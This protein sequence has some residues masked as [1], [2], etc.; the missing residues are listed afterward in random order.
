MGMA[1]TVEITSSA[2]RICRENHDQI[3]GLETLPVPPG[4]DP[5]ASL[6]TAQISGALGKVTVVM[7]HQDMLLRT[8]LQPPCP[9][10][11]L[12]RIVRFELQGISREEAEPTETAWHVVQG[13]G[14]DDMRI[15]AMITKRSLITALS[16]ALAAHG[17]KLAGLVH[18]AVG[19]YHA[20]KRQDPSYR[21]DA[22]IADIGGKN[23]HLALVRDGELLFLRSQTPGMDDLT[24]A[25]AELRSIAKP[26]AERL[27]AKLGKG[28][29]DDLHE[30]IRRQV[31]ALSGVIGNNVRFAKAQLHLDA[32]EPKAIYLAG[33]GAQV[34]GFTEALAERMHA[35]VRILNPFAGV[36]MR[37]DNEHLDRVAALPSPWVA[38]FGAALADKRELD[39]LSEAR[40]RRL[41]FWRSDGAVR[42]ACALALSL[43]L[44]AGV[45][46]TLAGMSYGSVVE[47]LRG[48]EES[49]GLVP[50]AKKVHDELGVLREQ[51]TAAAAKVS[52]IDG[53]R[54]PGRIAM[55][56]LSAI[57]E[58]QEPN[59]CPVV[60]RNF[61]VTRKPGLVLVDL[62]GYAQSGAKRS[63]AEVLRT[64]E[65]QLV[66]R[67]EP[68]SSIRSLPKPAARDVQDFHYEIGVAD[69]PLQIVSKAAYANGARKG[70]A[71]KLGWNGA[72][73]PEA[74]A[75]AMV[76]RFLN[77]EDEMKIQVVPADES[78]M[79]EFMWDEKRHSLERVGR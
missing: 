28:A 36:I 54:R 44:M 74:V 12:A 70:L 42:V 62:Q 18:P 50:K 71:V 4:I 27:I 43:L 75:M 29:P 65:Q 3:V 31:Q 20:F 6:A 60:L 19:M 34:H 37:M 39:A 33:A 9:P 45:R 72:G 23:I 16:K 79:I 58:Q 51:K 8:M 32:F 63:T 52:F 73:E 78:G 35:A 38:C 11:R 69:V 53:E 2:I 49:Q 5:V 46:Q 57:S 21:D 47:Q 14:G 17:G 48:D 59:T 64:F 7:Q 77:G 30:V 55:E 26:E 66:R 67:Y 40:E 24:N 13:M 1:T 41:A 56:M 76:D 68:I 15:L 22:V 25:V 61:Q 10:E